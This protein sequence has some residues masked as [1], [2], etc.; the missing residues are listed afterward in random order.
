MPTHES[1]LGP[2][3]GGCAMKGSVIPVFAGMLKVYCP[4]LTPVPSMKVTV[5]VTVQSG[6]GPEHGRP[7]QARGHLKGALLLAFT[8][9][10]SPLSVTAPPRLRL[11]RS[12]EHT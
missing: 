5:E 4:L 1:P 8:V 11:M 10:T 6:N 9:P 2:M 7:K 12:E 3:I